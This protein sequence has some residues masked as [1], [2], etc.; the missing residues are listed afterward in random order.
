M[1]IYEKYFPGQLIKTY[2]I[3]A[4][5]SDAEKIIRKIKT[6]GFSDRRGVIE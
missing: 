5:S 6:E 3:G 4:I 2:G 1:D